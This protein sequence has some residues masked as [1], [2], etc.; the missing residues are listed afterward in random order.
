[1]KNFKNLPVFK[2]ASILLSSVLFSSQGFAYTFTPEVGVDV[3]QESNVFKDDSD[4]E[5]TIIAPFV[6]LNFSESNATINTNIDF[7]AKYENYQDDSFSAIDLYDVNAFLDWIILPERFVWAFEDYAVTQRINVQ[8]VE[9]PE[10]LQTV[11]VF[12][13]GPDLSYQQEV[14][15]WLAKLRYGDS[16][17]SSSNADS[18]FTSLTGAVRR[19]INE[20]SRVTAA[21][22]VRNNDFDA[23]FLDDY[24][25]YKAFIS[26]SRDLPTGDF[27]TDFG[28]NSI[29]L[30]SGTKEDEP[31]LKL[32]L[33]MEPVGGVTLSAGFVDEITDSVGRA[34]SATES[35]IISEEE[36]SDQFI[37]LSDFTSTGV[38]QTKDVSL[39]ISSSAGTLSY[40]IA[41]TVSDK[42][43]INNRADSKDMAG[44]I[45]A[46]LQLSDLLSFSLG[47]A[48]QEVDYDEST[49]SAAISDEIVRGYAS[50]NYRLTNT[51]S[52]RVGYSTEERTSDDITRDFENDII[53]FSLKYKGAVK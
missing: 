31:Y 15:T 50:L 46:N 4:V 33:N 49:I 11:N 38:Y 43:Y 30:D 20:Y 48:Y 51:I 34:Y 3:K 8:G 47:G 42:D 37:T 2:S 36:V 21:L 6:G 45:F 16:N 24:D 35:R 41:G 32:L 12:S 9:T 10:N 52:T 22:A 13:T 40:G 28:F 7:F 1:M 53:F 23:A 19:D 44:K 5:D 14:W 18:A 29:E 17:Y 39:G 26:Y 27:L 25:I